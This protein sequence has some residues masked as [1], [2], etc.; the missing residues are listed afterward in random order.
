MYVFKVI[1]TTTLW[2]LWDASSPTLENVGFKC[3]W[4]CQRLRL[5]AVSLSLSL[6]TQ[7]ADVYAHYWLYL[8]NTNTPSK[9]PFNSLALP[10]ATAELTALP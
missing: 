6:K 8:L 9:L 10:V 4:S 1:G 2:H 7:T 3:I 5:Y